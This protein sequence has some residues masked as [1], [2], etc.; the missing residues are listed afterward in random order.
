MCKAGVSC[1]MRCSARGDPSHRR[2]CAYH[3]D[4]RRRFLGA[5]EG[6]SLGVRRGSTRSRRMAGIVGN[7]GRMDQ[8]VRSRIMRS[9][10]QKD[11]KPEL[12]VRRAVHAMGFRFRL[13]RRD[14]PGSPDLVLPRL[15]KVIFV[16]GCFWHQHAGCRSA[17]RPRTR[18]S[19]WHPKL[20]GN[21]ARDARALVDLKMLGWNALVLWECELRDPTVL[22]T[23]LLDFLMPSCCALAP[24]RETRSRC[25]DGPQDRP[26]P[27]SR[28]RTKT[29]TDRSRT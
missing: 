4:R 29:M 14:L 18:T 24:R 13:H 7:C 5:G 26:G 8:A 25:P 28:P 12:V 10:R 15:R 16:H 20:D 21:V 22:Q 3:L 23:R 9:I 19:Y 17:T 1:S 6:H 2:C 11:T 27:A